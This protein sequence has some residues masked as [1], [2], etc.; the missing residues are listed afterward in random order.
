M[1]NPDAI[2]LPE[3]NTIAVRLD[4]AQT[5]INSMVLIRR[6]EDL[7]GLNPWIYE[8]AAALSEEQKTRHSLVIIGFHYAVLPTRYWKDTPSYL[9]YMEKSDPIKLRDQLLDFYI[10]YECSEMDAD[11]PDVDIDTLL[12]DKEFFLDY[13]VKKFTTEYIDHEIESKA[14]DLLNDPPEMKRQIVSHL[15]FM[16]EEYYKEEWQRIKPM[17][18]DAVMAFNQVDFNNMSRGEIA[19]YIIGRDVDADFF[20]YVGENEQIIFVP[21]AHN[22]P[23]LGKFDYKNS[24]GVIFGARLPEDTEMHAPD[25][26]RNEITVRLSA[27][28]DDLRLNILKVIAE[29]GEM[30]SQEIMDKLEMSQSAASR[31]LKQLSAT[32]Y[33]TERRC[34]GA[35]CYALNEERVQ[36]TLRAVG[37][38]LLC[39]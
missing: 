11:I 31:H 12:A 27:L 39:E 35:K 30:K 26:S 37:A 9:A 19:K 20:E 25:L 28:A 15:N 32:G 23:Y 1:P 5:F 3:V 21:S 8:T 17:L 33:L 16:W 36:D 4:P 6:S 38:F 18:D 10:N 22:G 34:S 2:V 13:L 29:E 24:H 7:S 14:F